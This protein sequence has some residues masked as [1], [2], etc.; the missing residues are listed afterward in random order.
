MQGFRFGSRSDRSPPKLRRHALAC[1]RREAGSPYFILAR[2]RGRWIPCPF[3]DGQRVR[4]A[5]LLE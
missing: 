1:L 4:V 2:V 5:R 3:E